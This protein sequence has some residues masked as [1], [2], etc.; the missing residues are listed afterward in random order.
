MLRDMV[1]QMAVDLGTD[2]EWIAVAHY[3]TEHP[4]VHLVLRGVRS[5]GRSLHFRPDYVKHGIRGVA[6]DMC[7]RQLGDCTSQGEAESSAAARGLS[8]VRTASMLAE[9]A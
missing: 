8:S 5:D 1:Q 4:H 3:N 6:E 9:Q 7:T 2:L